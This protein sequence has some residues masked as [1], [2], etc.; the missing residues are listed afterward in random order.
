MPV[1][2]VNRLGAGKWTRAPSIT[3]DTFHETLRRFI[4]ARR[5]NSVPTLQAARRV[6]QNALGTRKGPF[7]LD[8]S[9]SRKEAAT[10]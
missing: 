5:W 10:A 2:T 4:R 8:L 7:A 6:N 9:G 1:S 3:A